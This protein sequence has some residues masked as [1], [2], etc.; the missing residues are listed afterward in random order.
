MQFVPDWYLWLKAFH[1][2]AVVSWMAALFY[3]PRLFVY[4]SDV[5]VGSQSSEL[6]K[7]ME[8]RLMKAIMR[9]ASVAVLLSGG[10]LLW[11]S[12]FPLTSFWV[13]GKLLAV[14]LMFLFHGFLERCVGEFAADMRPR[15][16]KFFRVINEVPTA[17]L[18]VIVIFVVVKPLQ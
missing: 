5:N 7:T 18:I 14:V 4:H 6:F 15:D 17:L 2:I 10:L 13:S 9:P 12:G 8:R 11:L 16:G 3:M 1:I